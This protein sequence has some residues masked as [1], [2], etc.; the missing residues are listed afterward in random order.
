MAQAQ[1]ILI[2]QALLEHN[3]FGETEISLSELHSTVSTL[4]QGPPESESTL[5]EE[6]FEVRSRLFPNKS[7]EYMMINEYFVLQRLP[8]FKTWRTCNTGVT[9]ENKAKN[10][11]ESVIPCEH[12]R[13]APTPLRV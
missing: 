13:H 9:E 3:Q 1:Y 6:E 10:R 11:C 12:R 8:S 5:M 2:H 4:K 7:R